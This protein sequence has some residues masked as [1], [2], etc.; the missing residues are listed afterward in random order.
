MRYWILT[1]CF[2]FSLV[3]SACKTEPKLEN[4]PEILFSGDVQRILSSHC[5][6][7]GCHG[8]GGGEAGSLLT[9]EDVIG[10]VKTGNA[11][12][13]TLYQV[14]TRR[15]LV[16][17]R[18]PPSGYASVSAEDVKLIYWWIEQGAKNN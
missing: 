2:V 7:Q 13:S 3:F 1:A 14:I 12:G 6:F 10:H 4:V 18:M 5:N 15:G 16:P 8:G 17:E 9:Y 11:H